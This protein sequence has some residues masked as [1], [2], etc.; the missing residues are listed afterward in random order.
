MRIRPTCAGSGSLK[1][2]RRLGE[3]FDGD[4]PAGDRELVACFSGL[5]SSHGT[6]RASYGNGGRGQRIV[7]ETS[8]K[9]LE[10]S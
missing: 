6:S 1:D 3:V 4:L 8:G 10:I 2:Q 5:E 9:N 7:H